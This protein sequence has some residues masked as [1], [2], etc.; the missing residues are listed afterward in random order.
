MHNVIL[1]LFSV[2][3]LFVFFIISYFFKMF[4][5]SQFINF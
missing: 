4:D 5:D 3:C 2:V 1:Q